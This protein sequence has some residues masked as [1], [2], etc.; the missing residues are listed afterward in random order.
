M[1]ES[2]QSPIPGTDRPAGHRLSLLR[3]FTYRILIYGLVIYSSLLLYLYFI[4]DQILYMPDYPSRRVTATPDQVGLDYQ[5][6]TL[7][8]EDGVRLDGW[9]LPHDDPRATLL[10]FHGNAGNISHRLHS[11]K[12][13]H[14]LG[15]AVLIID[16][17]GYGRSEGEPSEAGT[18]RDADAAWRYLT[19]T[20]NIPPAQVLLLGR[21]LGGAVAAYTASRHGALG[22][23][24][25]STFSSAPEMAAWLYP[26]APARRL[27]R[28]GYD[29]QSRL[30]GIRIPLL[31]VHSREDELIPYYQGE[32][33]YQA[34]RS[35]KR[36]LAIS[37]GHND[38]L[39]LNTQRYTRALDEFIDLCLEPPQAQSP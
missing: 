2:S 32:A 19:E 5:P 31:V 1:S 33:L 10:F 11:L 12:L 4:Q 36:F 38:G 28:F 13:F 20:R 34:G 21:S 22:L 17:R 6:V 37:G 16:Y 3:G 7:T 27:T 24:L 18:Y 15:L 35:P 9:F 29:T 30:A 23:V 26:W 25:E 14:D 8:A 39:L